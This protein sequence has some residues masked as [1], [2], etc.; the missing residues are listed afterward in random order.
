[1]TRRSYWSNSKFANWVRGVKKP[2][3]LTSEDWYSWEETVKN[4]HP[5]KYWVAESF[6]SKLQDVVFYIPDMITK[7]RQYIT[8]R[9]I[10][11]THALTGNVKD[12]PRGQWQDVG[13]RFVPCLFNE[14]VDFVEIEK[15][16]CMVS[17]SDTNVRAK[18]PSN[19]LDDGFTGRFFQGQIITGGQLV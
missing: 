5:F 1:M 17:W 2:T 11:H 15:A 18:Y 4:Q 7:A 13:S 16:L 9:F 3:A 6:L 8:N 14:L 12:C 19:A 10:D